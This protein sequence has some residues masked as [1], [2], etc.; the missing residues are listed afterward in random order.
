MKFLLFTVPNTVLNGE[1]PVGVMSRNAFGPESSLKARSPSLATP[2]E[3]P[4]MLRLAF[5][6]TVPV[7]RALSTN[8]C[9]G[10]ESANRAVSDLT[11]FML[12]AEDVMAVR[13]VISGLAAT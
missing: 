11:E 1:G 8:D 5:G 10:A 6:V 12:Y 3:S 13:G 7:T 4:R 2:M 9:P